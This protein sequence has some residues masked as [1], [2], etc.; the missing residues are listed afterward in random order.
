MEYTHARHKFK[1]RSTVFTSLTLYYR[2][3]DPQ[4]DTSVASLKAKK[5]DIQTQLSQYQSEIDNLI[6]TERIL[7]EKYEYIYLKYKILL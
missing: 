2:T 3:T 6:K 5:S 1:L 4:L 7:K